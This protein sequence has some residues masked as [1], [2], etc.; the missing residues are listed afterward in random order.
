MTSETYNLIPLSALEHY[1]YC[2]RQCALIHVEQAWEENLYTMRGKDVHEHVHDDSS[3][4]LAGV[5]LERSL[6]IWN[7]RLHL[8]GKADLV[9]FR[10]DIPCPVEYKSGHRRRG[11]PETIQL[12]GQAL[13]L[14]EM[15]GVAVEKGMLY[16]HASRERREV[17]FS[18]AMRA[19]VKDT[20]ASVREMMDKRLVPPPVNDKRCDDCSL[21]ESCMPSVIAER[22]RFHRVVEKMFELE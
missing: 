15:F 1:A 6:P 12:C 19:S 21:K 4:E 9:E 16:W 22:Q 17:L 3:H 5:R 20:A 14:E 13:C 7:C 10:G 2:P 18:P 8:I 11:A